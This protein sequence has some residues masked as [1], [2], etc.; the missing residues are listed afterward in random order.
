MRPPLY[1]LYSHV[2]R[3][4][5]PRHQP[6]SGWGRVFFT[7]QVA[8]RLCRSCI[9]PTMLPFSMRSPFASKITTSVGGTARPFQ[10][11]TTYQS[12]V[13]VG[14]CKCVVVVCVVCVRSSI[15]FTCFFRSFL[16]FSGGKNVEFVCFNK[17]YLILHCM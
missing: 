13:C 17:S 4:L 1:V 16:R 6:T 11:P 12:S 10:F 2:A 7:V 15:F 14:V 3:R 5:L 8:L 9:G